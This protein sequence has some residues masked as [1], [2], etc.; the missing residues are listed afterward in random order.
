VAPQAGGAA[1][2]G[3]EPETGGGRAGAQLEARLVAGDEAGAWALMEA[4]L[5]SGTGPD[6]LL[7]DVLGPTLHSIGGHWADG[8]LSI[9]HEHR[10]S[11]V[12]TRLLGRLGARFTPRGVKR[13]AIVLAAPAGDLHALPVAMGANLLRW[14]GFEVV[15]L[16]ADT[17][18]QALADAVAYEVAHS[19]PR[20][21]VA[22]LVCTVAGSPLAAQAAIA[23]VRRTSPGVPLLLGGAAVTG[24]EHARGLG[25]DDYTGKRGDDLVR[26]VEA[27]ARQWD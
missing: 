25:A 5:A 15:E 8:R 18:G 9:V 16:G 22:G 2:S 3:D 6:V 20:P 23:E 12:A 7:I 10:A 27:V 1:T 17:P 24:A 4:A 26:A 19:R 13:G 14:A 11:V 21:V